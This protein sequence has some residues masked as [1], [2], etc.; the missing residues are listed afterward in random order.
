MSNYKYCKDKD[1]YFETKET[2]D[3][4]FHKPIP[5]CTS[6]TCDPFKQNCKTECC[7]GLPKTIPNLNSIY[8][9]P[10]LTNRIFD[11]MTLEN[12]LFGVLENLQF[13]L[14]SSPLQSPG[15]T[16]ESNVCVDRVSFK[17]DAIGA[18]ITNNILD[19]KITVCSKEVNPIA[20]DPITVNG[21]PIA[22]NFS[23]TINNIPC[24]NNYD[25]HKTGVNCKVLERNLNFYISNLVI[26]VTGRAGCLPFTAQ[27]NP[28]NGN[29]VDVLGFPSNFNFFGKICLPHL[30]SGIL[31]KETF[32][33]YLSIECIEP[34]TLLQQD[35]EDFFFEAN[36]ESSLS[37]IKS[38]YDL[39]EDKIS[40]LAT[41]T[42]KE[43]Y[44]NNSEKK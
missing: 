44:C 7:T 39:V 24:C 34:T 11:C 5:C 41:R 27:S 6:S 36:V 26:T 28:I 17:Y 43:Q 1:L 29:L 42:P 23:F 10:I 15:Y 21:T 22:N 12:S 32:K 18:T 3:E 19:G 37:I 13:A 31:L 8:S 4:H 40:V 20:I 38:L 9:V 14:I 30:N 25:N 16:N 33:E 35:G 2:H